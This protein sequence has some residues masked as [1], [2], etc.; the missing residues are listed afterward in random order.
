MRLNR[1]LALCGIGARR[2]VEKLIKEGRVKVNGVKIDKPWYD[3]KEKDVVELD[4]RKLD[5]KNSTY[6][7]INKPSNVLTT[8][9]D[10]FGRR[11]IISL[12]P[13]KFKHLFPVGRLDLDAKGLVLLTND[14]E[15][16]Y[17]LTH[18]KFEI[19]KE[20]IVKTKGKLLKGCIKKVKRGIQ[21][22]KEIYRV[23]RIK[24]LKK[25]KENILFKLILTEGKHREIKK[26]MKKINLTVTEI[27]RIRIGPLRLGRL[28]EGEWRYLT[29]KEIEAL[30]K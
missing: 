9:K 14:G 20:Y 2:K 25:D 10:E 3:V 28:K 23:K 1:Y 17:K 16:A 8:K 15:L 12:L 7:I 27:K 19:E 11:T 5:L 6:I 30:K 26:I 21:N 24:I 13:S 18:P 29:K 22:D 4:G